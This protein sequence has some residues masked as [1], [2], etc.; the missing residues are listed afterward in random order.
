MIDDAYTN[1]GAAVESPETL[2]D[3]ALDQGSEG[4]TSTP[5]D[6]GVVAS[7][8]SPDV[9]AAP[10]GQGA[11]ISAPEPI[12][13]NPPVAA[14]MSEDMHINVGP[15]ATSPTSQGADAAS[16]VVDAT[17][18]GDD[19]N[20]AG[21]RF[22]IGSQREPLKD[23]PSAPIRPMGNVGADK[24]EP[25][26]EL[27]GG[28]QVIPPPQVASDKVP[29]TV[30]L[31]NLRM[32]APGELE[33]LI[34]QEMDGANIDQMV[35][36]R[37]AAVEL[38]LDARVRGKV[39][40]IHQDTVFFEL[41]GGR[42][43]AAPQ[44]KFKSLPALGSEHEVIVKG[45]SQEDGVFELAIPGTTQD[46]A[47]WEDLTEGAVVEAKITGANIGGLECN[48][49]GIRGFI[50]A[51]QIAVFRVE[52]MS[53]FIGQK[54]ECLVVE[55]KRSK[56]NLVLSRRAIIEREQEASR[57]Q[58]LESIHEG[59]VR[60]GLVRSLQ[61]FGA[62]IDLGGVD[63]LIHIS[64]LSWERIKHPSEVLE[65]GQRIKVKVERINRESGKITLLFSDLAENPW[66][67]AGDRYPSGAKVKGTVSRIAEFGAFVKLEPGIEGLI[68]ISELAH[69]RVW[70][71]TD[72]VKEGQE[73]ESKVLNCDPEN[74][75][76]SLSLK[77]L[78][79][80]PASAK[81]K[82]EEPEE[83]PETQPVASNPKKLKALKGGISRPSGGEQF[84]LRW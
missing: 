23:I 31:P 83:L 6:E 77:A 79:P 42:Q 16:H 41:P 19:A 33:E 38:T 49:A 12:M 34:A 32:E 40:S 71:A 20:A 36:S 9:H 75:R 81:K 50:P 46:V 58:V 35:A 60:E 64:K 21:Q 30:A 10:E 74:Q 57:K 3:Q 48:V 53:E 37:G 61:A 84:G 7:G 54:L 18:Q 68:H 28:V 1:S 4:K 69:G 17:S 59:E 52:N 5:H 24:A 47:A 45:V 67:R 29:H 26:K 27:K 56:R 25:M 22:R 80:P 2:K 55:A 82:E 66:L 11:I 13:V 39:V 15:E 70:R 62:F 78:T 72:V 14:P 73:V 65:V 8:A 43:G 51:S 44:Q 76:I 63:G